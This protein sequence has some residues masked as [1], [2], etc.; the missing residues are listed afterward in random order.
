MHIS[1]IEL[2]CGG[3]YTN[4]NVVGHV[5]VIVFLYQLNIIIIIA[6]IKIYYLKDA[7]D[8]LQSIIEGV[9]YMG[10]QPGSSS[11]IAEVNLFSSG[12]L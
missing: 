7:A 11:H 4:N 1:S 9:L 10:S 8:I 5:I 6:T 12:V 2:C 3:F